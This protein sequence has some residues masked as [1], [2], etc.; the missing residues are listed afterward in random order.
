MQMQP[1]QSNCLDNSDKEYSYD[2]RQ[3]ILKLFFWFFKLL[4]VDIKGRCVS[5][6]QFERYHCWWSFNKCVSTLK[7]SIKANTDE[8]VKGVSGILN[9]KRLYY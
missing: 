6:L 5:E 7:S 3:F 9:E 8:I 1:F 4:E 2:V